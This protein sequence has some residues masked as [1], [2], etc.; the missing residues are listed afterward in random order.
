[1]E[2]MKKIVTAKDVAERCGYSVGTVHT[3]FANPSKGAAKSL[4]ASTKELIFAV[5]KEMGYDPKKASYNGR[6]HNHLSRATA[7]EIRAKGKVTQHDIANYIGCGRVT[8]TQVLNGRG[9]VS[10]EFRQRVLDAAKE[11]GYIPRSERKK[12]SEAKQRQYFRLMHNNCSSIEEENQYMEAFRSMGYSNAMISRKT[13]YTIKTIRRRIGSQPD[14]MTKGN[15]IAAQHHRAAENRRRK[16]Y[17]DT[18]LVTT[19]NN[20][21]VECAQLLTQASDLLHKS[22]NL[23]AEIRKMQPQVANA[24]LSTVKPAELP[25]EQ[26]HINEMVTASTTLQ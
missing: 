8:V 11:L 13:G 4:K 10:Q 2:N 5:A 24:K 7:E 12:E 15:R 21:V 20:M 17:V 6:I 26:I 3:V 1:M 23:I 18:H 25:T 22:D 16:V 14:D 19:Y 9:I